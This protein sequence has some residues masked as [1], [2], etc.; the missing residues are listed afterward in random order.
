[1]KKSLPIYKVTNGA[2]LRRLAAAEG[3]QESVN[4]KNTDSRTPNIPLVGCLA[5]DTENL[6]T[7]GKE[8]SSEEIKEAFC[9]TRV[10]A[11]PLSF[12]FYSKPPAFLILPP[13]CNLSVPRKTIFNKQVQVTVGPGV[14]LECGD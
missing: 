6:F 12:Y 9:I 5:Y 13:S 3:M 1:M 11:P 14:T 8:S 7:A 4:K 10:T 2:I